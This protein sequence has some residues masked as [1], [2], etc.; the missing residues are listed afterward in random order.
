MSGKSYD[1]CCFQITLR[2]SSQQIE[3]AK[4]LIEAKIKEKE[5]EDSHKVKD[6][7]QK[8]LSQVEA[9]LRVQIRREIPSC[10]GSY[11]RNNGA[12]ERSLNQFIDLLSHSLCHLGLSVEYGIGTLINL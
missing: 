8:K 10:H 1:F 3:M 4:A 5:Q 12:R 2:G 6:Q 9:W 7:N 11:L